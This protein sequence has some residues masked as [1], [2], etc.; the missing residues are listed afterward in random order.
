MPGNQTEVVNGSKLVRVCNDS[1]SGNY[2]CCNAAG[3][4][5]EQLLIIA[6]NY[7]RLQLCFLI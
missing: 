3:K 7:S 2:S 5:L 6:G 1:A 4:C